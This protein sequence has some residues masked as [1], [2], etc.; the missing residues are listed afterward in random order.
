MLMIL[1]FPLARLMIGTSIGTAAPIVPLPI[2]AAPFV[3]RRE[4]E[5]ALK[6]VDGGIIPAAR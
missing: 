6:E 1:R 4:I 3:A 5:S 2:A